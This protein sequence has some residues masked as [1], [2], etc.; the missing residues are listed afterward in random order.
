LNTHA[1]RQHRQAGYDQ[2]GKNDRCSFHPA[3]RNG[4]KVQFYPRPSPKI[5]TNPGNV[6]QT[7]LLFP[8]T[9]ESVAQRT[10]RRRPSI[11]Q[12]L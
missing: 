5:G 12:Y 6:I 3:P 11:P 4:S 9:G 7:Q 1:Q 10:V 2:N 8:G